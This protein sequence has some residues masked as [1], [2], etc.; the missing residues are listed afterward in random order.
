MKVDVLKAFT[1]YP[2][3]VKTP[4]EVGETEMPKAFVEGSKL[5]EKGLVRVHL[6][7]RKSP[8]AESD[9]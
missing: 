3:G 8:L 5:V 9:S 1:G 7:S 6:P 4:F 2:A